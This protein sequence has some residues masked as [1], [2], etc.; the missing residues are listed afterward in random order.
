MIELKQKKVS[1]PPSF[2]FLLCNWWSE[3][4]RGTFGSLY[5]N[6]SFFS[7][8]SSSILFFLLVFLSFFLLDFHFS[9]SCSVLFLFHLL[10][11]FF[12]LTITIPFL[13]SDL[14][15]SH[16]SFLYFLFLRVRSSKSGEK[17]LEWNFVVRKIGEKLKCILFW[18]K[19]SS[20]TSCFLPLFHHLHLKYFDTLI[21][22]Q[23]EG[24]WSKLQHFV[25]FLLVLSEN[26]SPLHIQDIELMSRN[27]RFE[28]K[29]E[30]AR[31][32][33]REKER[34]MKERKNRK[35]KEIE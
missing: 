9:S 3:G 1:S 35:K 24:E 17:F 4:N 7:F 15:L 26:H 20:L 32:R 11:H 30:K 27:R 33:V 28:R 25:S 2:F 19:I 8:S 10:P 18:Q 34:E 23:K 29:K 12:L 14:F 6:P 31:E 5:N 21:Q 13:W 22:R 16:S